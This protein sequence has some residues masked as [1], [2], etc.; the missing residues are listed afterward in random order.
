M[1]LAVTIPRVVQADLIC[2][3]NPVFCKI[4]ALNPK[5]DSAFA[6]KLSTIIVKNAQTFGLD[7]MHS[8]AIAMQESAFANVNRMGAVMTKDGKLVR[9]VTDV[10]VFQIHV[11]TIAYLGIDMQRLMTDLDYQG[12]WHAK[13]LSEKIK[14]CSSKR[15]KLAV[16]LG[17]EWSC[18]HSFTPSKRKVYLKD[19]GVHLA[20]IKH[21]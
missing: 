4:K 5:V 20:K 11:A 16:T 10:G 12:Y 8:V 1:T 2:K 9:G 21:N 17:N 19:V 15:S 7:P 18:Y 13:I 3:K 14:V 6:Q